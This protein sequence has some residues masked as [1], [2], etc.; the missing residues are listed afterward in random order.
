[1]IVFGLISSVFDLLTFG[2]LLHVFRAGEAAFQTSWFVISLL[3]ELVVVLLLR[4]RRP[5][6]RSRPSRLL[7]WSTL[8]V[9][10]ATLAVPFLGRLSA[11]FG[12]VPL[13]AAEMAAVLAIVA[14][15]VAATEI[16]KPWF[17]R[18]SDAAGR[19]KPGRNKDVST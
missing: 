10:V 1:M 6:F 2:L 17:Y 7:L 3:T 15:Y 11:V 16:A 18:A 19:A 13:S 5:F 8:T 4:T 12:F 9:A 14:G